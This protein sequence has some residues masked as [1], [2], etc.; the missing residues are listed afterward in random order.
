MA[1]CNEHEPITEIQVNAMRILR[2]IR[3][4]AKTPFPAYGAAYAICQ[5]LQLPYMAANRLRALIQA[6]RL[7]LFNLEN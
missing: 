7:K 6:E 2:L 1:V 4:F 5:Q 3:T